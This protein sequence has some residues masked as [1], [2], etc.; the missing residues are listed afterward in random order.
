MPCEKSNRDLE[1][2]ALTK[3]D[4]LK[5]SVGLQAVQDLVHLLAFCLWCVCV[6]VCVCACACAVAHLCVHVWVRV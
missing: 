4:Y 3:D 2:C 5:L 6:C 1:E